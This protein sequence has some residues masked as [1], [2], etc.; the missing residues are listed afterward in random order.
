MFS[1]AGMTCVSFTTGTLA[2]WAPIY[3][4][5]SVL[6]SVGHADDAK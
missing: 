6:A 1:S 4:Y 5:K 2:F 3:V